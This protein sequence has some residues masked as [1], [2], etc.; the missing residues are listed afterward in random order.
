L[1]V[2]LT[3]TIVLSAVTGLLA[4]IVAKAYARYPKTRYW[5]F[6]LIALIFVCLGLSL[7]RDGFEHRDVLGEVLALVCCAFGIGIATVCGRHLYRPA[8]RSRPYDSWAEVRRPLGILGLG[9][10]AGIPW[11]VWLVDVYV[12]HTAGL[13]ARTP[14]GMVGGVVDVG[15]A[16]PLIA[17]LALPVIRDLRLRESLALLPLSSRRR[18]WQIGAGSLVLGAVVGLPL[19]VLWDGLWLGGQAT[20]LH[21]SIIWWWLPRLLAVAC[22]LLLVAAKGSLSHGDA[23]AVS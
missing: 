7:F 15:L 8:P 22:L 10:G 9:A 17:G 13:L 6:L 19:V 14:L 1:T 11:A 3:A 18:C 2:G 4:A 16:S 5:Y 21:P 23:P 12:V 20:I